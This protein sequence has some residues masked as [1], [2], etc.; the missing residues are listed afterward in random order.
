MCLCVSVC[1]CVC[2]CARVRVCACAR[3][4]VC[5]CVRVCVCVRVCACVCVSGLHVY[6]SPRMYVFLFTCV[7]LHACMHN[8]II[9]ALVLLKIAIHFYT[10]LKC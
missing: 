5:A 9:N 10:Q 8:I 4:R 1:V 7:C 3:V 2:A 6:L